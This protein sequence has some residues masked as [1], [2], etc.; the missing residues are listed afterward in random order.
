[1]GNL[2]DQLRFAL[3]PCRTIG[4]TSLKVRLSYEQL[5][6]STRHFQTS[7]QFG[8]LCLLCI[9]L[10][11]ASFALLDNLQDS[12]TLSPGRTISCQGQDQP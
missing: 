1:M 10:Q 11:Q 2:T 8:T 7:T 9:R 3:Q 6:G 5:Q 12:L 4:L